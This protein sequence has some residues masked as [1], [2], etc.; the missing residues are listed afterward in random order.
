MA[1]TWRHRYRAEQRESEATL[2]TVMVVSNMRPEV[3]AAPPIKP[4]IAKPAVPVGTIEVRLGQAVVK[5]DGHC[6]PRYAAN[7]IEEPVIMISLALLKFEWVRRYV[8]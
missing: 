2:L 4:E 8:G 3:I 5:V 1:F 6:R 7:R